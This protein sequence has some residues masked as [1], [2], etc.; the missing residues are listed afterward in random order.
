M[1]RHLPHRLSVP[2][3][4]FRLI[5]KSS[6][7]NPGGAE[8]SAVYATLLKEGTADARPVSGV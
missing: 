4:T 7:R 6:V 8:P 1:G 2:R 3:P 5:L